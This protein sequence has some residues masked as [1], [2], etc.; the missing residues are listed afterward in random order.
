MKSFLAFA[1]IALTGLAA[2]VASCAYNDDGAAADSY[3]AQPIA[4]GADDD[5]GDDAPGL[6]RSPV[7]DPISVVPSSGLP[8]GLFLMDANNNLDVVRHNTRVFLAFRTAPTH[9]AST[10]TRL[11][12][13]SSFDERHWDLETSFFYGRDLREPRL[14]SFNGRLFVYFALLG[15][16]PFDFEPQGMMVSEYLAPGVWSEPEL[17]Y[18]QGF[19][20]WRTKTI[21]GVPYMLA[22]IGGG[23]I[24]SL[25]PEP[26]RV[27]WLT[28]GDGRSWIPVVPGQAEVLSGGVSETDFVFLDDGSLRAVSRNEAGDEN[29]FGTK[30]CRADADDL[31]DWQCVDD[32]RKFDSPLLFRHGNDV[33]LIGRR[34]LTETGHYDLGRFD[35]PFPMRHLYY[36]LD[37][38]FRKKRCSLWRMDTDTLDI[39]FVLDL[40]SR[41]DT[42]FPGLLDEGGG[43][44]SVY[45][46]TSA[47]EGPDPVW[48]R[49]Q[50]DPTFVYRVNLE[51]P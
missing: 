46:Y 18:G 2:G 9:F 42:C 16:N 43:V 34:N 48:L 5:E 31:G 13:V 4:P 25:K 33:Y 35:L 6:G 38:W 12:I 36:E 51:L 8:S 49:G 22:Y 45:N 11:H 39:D 20:P 27:H 28:T 24:Y 7:S 50:I 26:I 23:A 19:I 15:K 29:G 30:I 14:L 17:F 3:P 44:Y 21:D 32:P 37:Y 40:P 10:D 41:G 1:V 47:L